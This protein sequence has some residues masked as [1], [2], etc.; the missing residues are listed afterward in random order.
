[1]KNKLLLNLSWLLLSITCWSIQPAVAAIDQKAAPQGYCITTNWNNRGVLTFQFT[2]RSLFFRSNAVGLVDFYG[3]NGMRYDFYTETAAPSNLQFAQINIYDSVGTLIAVNQGRPPVGYDVFLSFT[4]PKSGNYRILIT[5][6]NCQVLRND[7]SLYYR[8]FDNRKPKITDFSPKFGGPGTRIYLTGT[9][10]SSVTTYK[11]NNETFFIS[12]PDNYLLVTVVTRSGKIVAQST[13]GNDTTWYPFTALPYSTCTGIFSN[14]TCTG[15]GITQA[16]FGNIRIIDS[17][18]RCN[19][20]NENHLAVDMRDSG[21]FYRGQTY[22]VSFN[23]TTPAYAGFWL[24]K[25]RDGQFEQLEYVPLTANGARTSFSATI[26]FAQNEPL[27]GIMARIRTSNSSADIYADGGCDTQTNPGHAIDFALEVDQPA[28][29]PTPTIASASSV[30]ICQGQRITL[31][32]PQPAPGVYYVW[33]NSLNGDTLNVGTSG[34][35][36]VRAIAGS[37][38]S[39]ISN[40]VT[41]SVVTPP[42]QPTITAQ[43]GVSTIC[44]AS[45]V[46][47]QASFNQPGARFRWSNG[48]TT[49]TTTIRSAGSY[50]VQVGL[51]NCFSPVSQAF[52]VTTGSPAPT[53]TVTSGGG[54]SVCKGQ[55]LT[56]TS[57]IG[58]SYLWST[59]ATTRSISVSIAGRYWVRVSQGGSCLSDTSRHFVLNVISKP[60]PVKAT[61]TGNTTLCSGD[62]VRLSAPT[63]YNFYRWSNGATSR[64][65]FVKSTGRYWVSVSQ[66]G[67]CYS[68]SLSGYQTSGITVYPVGATANDSVYL[69]LDPT[70]TCPLPA[71]NPG[72]SLATASIIR[73]HSGVTLGA[74]Q[75]QSVVSTTTPAVEPQTRFSNRGGNW[76]K[77]ILPRSYYGLLATDNPTAINFV[78]NGDAVSGG[79]FVRE[80]KVEPGCGDFT[81]P[82]PIQNNISSNPY[83]V[84]VVVNQTPA[85]PVI[86]A[87]VDTNL[88]SGQTVTLTAPLG[89][90]YLWSNGATSR[91]ITVSTA[92]NYTVR[93]ISG[94][95]TSAVSRAVQVSIAQTP[96]TPTVTVTGPT[97]FCSGDSVVLTLPTGNTY[98]WSDNSALSRRVIR[99]SVNLTVRQ[100]SGR[101]TSVASAPVAITVNQSPAV[102]TFSY[103][104]NV[105]TV[106][107]ATAGLT[108]QWLLNGS[109]IPGAVNTSYTISQ[110]GSYSL[111]ARTAAG[112]IRQSPAT[113]VTSL[114]NGQTA[115]VYKLAPNPVTSITRLKGYE[116]RVIV[117]NVFTNTGQDVTDKTLF[118]QNTQTLDCKS[119]TSGVYLLKIL[120]DEGAS[121]LRLIKD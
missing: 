50:T 73:L 52:S 77:A 67:N 48:D 33:S 13:N 24:D 28:C 96:S 92:G 11:I 25:D 10:L 89:S 93:L 76:T 95:C 88:C 100:I 31:R 60:L 36:S 3:V 85:R 71:A 121:F 82:L 62:S 23:T 119:L 40:T 56:L 49:A 45:P 91:A 21:T 109:P 64:E 41:V 116:G 118:D 55:T 47:L 39:A 27:G 72:T 103:A 8:Q 46:V 19:A 105:L 101:C 108:F 66:N 5:T 15:P 110:S 63:G 79:W 112:C 98:L 83:A 113:T 37:C 35:Y 69:L 16:R 43:N 22:Q 84:N 53:P 114:K 59:G 18:T 9:A 111:I 1:M 74:N 17:T 44:G 97:T 34:T 38:T 86:S 102:P 68:D 6:S 115:M 57:S 90:T 14:I 51:A 87:G 65:I 12:P 32:A 42:S 99:N 29:P 7:L 104:N 2:Y 70:R 120:T 107:S 81:V 80:G 30:T 117:V 58:S 94:T 4:A 75:W 26:S 20:V 78:L 106:T 61:V 54:N